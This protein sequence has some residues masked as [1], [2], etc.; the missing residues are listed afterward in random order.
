MLVGA[1]AVALVGGTLAAAVPAGA[2]TTNVDVSNASVACDTVTGTLKFSTP[3]T[4]SAAT[5]GALTTTVKGAVAGCTSSTVNGGGSV[6]SGTLTGT[7]TSSGGT[8]CTALLGLAGDSGSL[9]IAWKAPKGYK[10]GPLQTVG[11]KTIAASVLSVSQ[12]NGT[13]YAV[14]GQGPWGSSYGQFQIGQTYGTTHINVSGANQ[15]FTGGDT[16][17]ASWINGVFSLGSTDG[18]ALCAGTGLK[19]VT[20]GIGGASVA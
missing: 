9:T 4:L 19:Q 8:N 3:L 13:E 6:F 16:G 5:T 11:A 2:S 12:V 17:H 7:L 1:A 20:F 15:D 14:T 10:F 18:F